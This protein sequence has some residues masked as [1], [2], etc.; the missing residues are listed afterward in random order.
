MN[1]VPIPE[2]VG[3]C[4]LGRGRATAEQVLKDLSVFFVGLWVI[5]VSCNVSTSE[6]F[7]VFYF[8][9]LL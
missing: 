2:S 4:L 5:S 1:E 8:F 6:A 9:R 3:T 7:R